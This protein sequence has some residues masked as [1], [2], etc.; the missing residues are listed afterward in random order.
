M[1]RQ[2]R[3]ALAGLALATGIAAAPCAWAATPRDQLVVAWNIDAISTFDPAQI[4]EVVTSEIFG[5][6]CDSLAAFDPADESK[7]IPA[8]AE[9]WDVSEDG[10]RITFRL[11]DKL[12]FADGR[13]ASAA[14]LAWSMQRVVKLNFGNAAQLTDY[15][16]TRDTVDSRITAP[17]DRTLVLALDKP[18]P[19]GLILQAVAANRVS[20]L[21]DRKTLSANENNGDMGNRYL[22][23]R[24]E[25]VGPY[26]LRQWNSGEVVVLEAN[27]DHWGEVPKLRRIIIRHVAE[28]G[29]QRLLLEKG[30]IDVA[31]NLT[32][33]DLR[34]LEGAKG[35]RLE[36]TRKPTLFYWGFNS[37]D[38]VF[39]EEKVRLAMRYLVDYDGLAKSVMAY[40][41]V[42][43]ASFVP[44]GSFGA[45]DEKEGQPFSLDIARARALLAEAGRPEGFETV[46]ILGSHPY[47][48][49][50]AQHIQANAAQAGVRIRLEQMANAQL[51]ARHRGREFQ[52]AM[53]GWGAGMPDAHANA[54]R[55]IFNPDNRVEAKLTQF[56][57]WRAAF[58]DAEANKQVEAALMERDEAKRAAIYAGLQRDMMQRGPAAFLFQTV[59]VAGVRDN[60]RN[61]TW[62]GFATYFDRMSKE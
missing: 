27:K 10:L 44:L 32:P 7:V 45:L 9:S 52:S 60:V 47:A 17:D 37:A 14:D 8:L 49:A 22:T 53:L 38:P 18:Y 1:F 59:Y 41:G 21:L 56:P 12:R 29:T 54:S 48:S 4:A 58:Q 20:A 13:A 35:V 55:L 15:G 11:R 50:I 34:A 39:A 26:R 33:E 42:P 30:D 57:S 5:N 61:W 28:A 6:T 40:D 36:R 19:P 3:L 16:F 24:T 62:N 46:M 31:R 23:S 25:C 2:P 43:R 51:F